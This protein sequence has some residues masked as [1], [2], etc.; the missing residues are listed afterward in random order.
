[1]GSLQ[2]DMRLG[3]FGGSFDPPHLGHLA[4]A[5][6]AAD[7]YNLSRVLLVPTAQQPLKPSGAV[8]AYHDRLAMVS[9]LCESD[10]RLIASD[11]EA[12]V[13]PPAPNYTIDTLKRIRNTQP[14]AELFVIVGADAF[15]DLPRWHSPNELLD[16]AEW[17]VVTRPHLSAH[18]SS[19]ETAAT[20]HEPLRLPPLTPA[21]RTRIHLLPT[22]DHPASATAIRAELAQGGD[23]LGMLS[24]RLLA[25]I[26]Q[27]HLYASTE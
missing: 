20:R 23:G 9:I 15:H 27:H 19:G 16:L 5:Q 24:P 11:L 18:A 21:Q 3:Y 13:S 7:S 22:V 14:D 25:Y 12:P 26:R 8:A 10:P 17:I 1:M 2:S 4:V 6:A